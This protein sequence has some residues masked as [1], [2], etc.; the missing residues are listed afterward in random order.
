MYVSVCV[1]VCVC[2]WVCF[3][4]YVSV[5]VC[6]CECV[7]LCLCMCVC[8]CLRVCVC[9]C[10]CMY[11]CVCVRVCVC[12][13]AHACVC[14]CAGLCGVRIMSVLPFSILDVLSAH[15]SLTAEK[16]CSDPLCHTRTRPS[17]PQSVP[18]WAT[19][20]WWVGLQPNTEVLDQP[21]SPPLPFT[22]AYQVKVSRS[23]RFAIKEPRSDY[24]RPKSCYFGHIEF[25]YNNV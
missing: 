6:V 16:A 3:C 1:C 9:V 24:L 25:F 19:A 10:V 8:V 7:C 18:H 17:Q 21:P 23:V 2:E 22:S 20:E 15:L 5:S 13:S 4:V 11:V 12:V 14:V